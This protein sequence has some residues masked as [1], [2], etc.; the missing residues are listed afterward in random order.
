M[1]LSK[2]YE[3]FTHKY[4]NKKTR[5][6]HGYLTYRY[7]AHPTSSVTLILFAGGMGFGDGFYTHFLTLAKHFSVITFNYSKDFRNNQDLAQA[8]ALLIRKL[9]LKN[10]YLIGQSYGGFISQIIAKRYPKLIKG[11]ILSNTSTLLADMDEDTKAN[12][13]PMLHKAEKYIKLDKFLPL[14][15]LKPI[16]KVGINKKLKAM[17]EDKSAGFVV[18]MDLFFSQCTNTHLLLMDTLLADLK[19]E[20]NLTATDFASYENEV[21]LLL[22]DDDETF[23]SSAKKALIDLMPSPVVNT[24]IKGGHLA[25]F[26]SF[27]EYIDAII[28]FI[29]ERN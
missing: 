2:E 17:P 5:L 22:S 25:A 28:S 7:A 21:L 9:D 20:L 12:L 1:S 29:N 4:P 27:D 14:P 15:L 19:N 6:A 3:D 18:L 26:I 10:V 23:V 11:M 16:L 13:M 8:I 24:S